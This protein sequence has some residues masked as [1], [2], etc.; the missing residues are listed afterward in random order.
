MILGAPWKVL[1][2]PL[3]TPG[4]PGTLEDQGHGGSMAPMTAGT[5]AEGPQGDKGG[6]TNKLCN[7]H[8]CGVKTVNN[9][10]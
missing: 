7:R 1:G 4:A 5:R 10:A 6:V 3:G 9:V 8:I 2:V